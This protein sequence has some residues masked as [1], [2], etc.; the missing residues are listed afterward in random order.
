MN[1]TNLLKSLIQTVSQ[2]GHLS[3]DLLF[4]VLSNTTLRRELLTY[5]EIVEALSQAAV[6]RTGVDCATVENEFSALL[7][8]E[9]AEI[10]ALKPYQQMA[11]HVRLCPWCAEMYMTARNIGAAQESGHLLPWPIKEGNAPTIPAPIVV[12]RM[13]LQRALHK[14]HRQAPVRRS[15]G[16]RPDPKVYTTSVPSQPELFIHVTLATA[17]NTMSPI[18]YLL[19][20]LKGVGP[21]ENRGIILQDENDTRTARTDENGQARFMDVPAAWLDEGAASDLILFVTLT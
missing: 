9:D 2:Q 18:P 16:T 19:V 8:V 4:R 17:E 1:T 11:L 10:D 20:T 14:F 15:G 5:T 3:D 13:E 21:C 12:P 6:E 7:L